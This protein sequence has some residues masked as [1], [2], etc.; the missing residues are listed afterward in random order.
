MDG[1]IHC[2]SDA[3]GS[4]FVFAVLAPVDERWDSSIQW[5]N[6]TIF[7]EEHF[8]SKIMYECTVCL[9]HFVHAE[10]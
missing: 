10:L 8:A 5:I 3:S 1:A 6:I 7:L 2:S 4:A 9:E